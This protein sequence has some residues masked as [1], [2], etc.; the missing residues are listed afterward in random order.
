MHIYLDYIQDLFH[1]SGKV[2]TLIM[3]MSLVA[4][5]V[6]VVTISSATGDYKIHHSDVI[7][8]AMASRITSVSIVY[9]A[10]CSGTDQRKHPSS[11]S[12][13]FVRP[14]TGEF[15]AQRVSNAENVF[16]WSHHHESMT[17]FPFFGVS[18]FTLCCGYK[19][20]SDTN[21]LQG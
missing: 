17:A 1:W 9:P 2:G 5:E 16:I 10:A 14:V 19:G 7:M 11:A 18:R 21:F 20:E 4:L 3:L 15:P 6:A 8:I 13:V 12:L